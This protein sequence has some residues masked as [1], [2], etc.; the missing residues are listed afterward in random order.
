MADQINLRAERLDRGMSLDDAA[1]KIGVPKN[2]LLGAETRKS[3]PRPASAFKIASFYG[4]K[5][6]EVWT[7][8]DFS[9]EKELAA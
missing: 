9:G 5:V 1:D 8:G 3:T 4:Y 2:V 6:T 7:V